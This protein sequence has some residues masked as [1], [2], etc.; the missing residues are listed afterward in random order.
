MEFGN[1][2]DYGY[3]TEF[4]ED[5]G[6]TE[7]VGGAGGGYGE[8]LPTE[9]ILPQG[10]AYG[11]TAPV[12]PPD[13]DWGN[14]M[15][16]TGDDGFSGGETMDP[17]LPPDNGGGFVSSDFK[18][19]S[20]VEDYEDATM[21]VVMDGIEGFTPVVGWLVCIDGPSK[22]ADYRLRAGYNYIGRSE[23]MDVCIKGDN[24]IGRE[25]HAMV[26]YD[27]EERVFFFGPVDGKSTVRLNG[28]MVMVPSEL[29]AN[30]KL[31]I[32]STQLMFVPL[33]GERFNWDV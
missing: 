1:G 2:N 33:C 18:K 7:P 22:G 27:Q 16:F 6:A 15:N 32:G 23:H 19:N 24:T 17:T 29:H 12:T 20:G 11:K 3:G 4:V 13:M 30:D 10:G 31:K 14:D 26:A 5:Y 9:T 28:K 21:P 8:T 25:R